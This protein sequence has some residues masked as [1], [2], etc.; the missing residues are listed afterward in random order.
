MIA[1][2]GGPLS[3]SQIVLQASV[4]I[5]QLNA[6]IIVGIAILFRINR[7][8]REKIG[9]IFFFFLKSILKLEIA[10]VIQLCNVHIWA[11]MHIYIM[12]KA[13]IIWIHLI[14]QIFAMKPC[15]LI[16]SESPICNSISLVT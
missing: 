10:D 13:R 7:K 9:L 4:T 3:S 5:C 8:S 2:T 15:H 14:Q 1:I 12:W 16:D 11:M 6:Q